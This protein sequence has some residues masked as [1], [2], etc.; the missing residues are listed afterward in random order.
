MAYAR[1]AQVQLCMS[2]FSRV[3]FDTLNIHHSNALFKNKLLHQHDLTF[4]QTFEISLSLSPSPSF[5]AL[6]PT[7]QAQKH[8]PKTLIHLTGII[9]S[10]VRLIASLCQI[11]V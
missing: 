1:E 9:L 3:I 8:K 2:T 4:L 10:A 7:Y 11:A 5:L 6:F